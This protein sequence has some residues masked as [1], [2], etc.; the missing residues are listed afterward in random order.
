M[1]LLLL[2]WMIPGVTVLDSLPVAVTPALQES[3]RARKLPSFLRDTVWIYTV[4]Q[5]EDTLRVVV[6]DVLGKH[7]PITFAVAVKGDTVR[8]VQVLVYRE[9]YGGE[10]QDPRFLAH[11]QGKTGR[12]PLVPGKS[13]PRIAGATISVNA[14]TLGVRRALWLLSRIGGRP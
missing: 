14:I 13:V 10:I 4:L 11:F 2:A 1:T 12:D 3:V 5:E 6:D 7:E 9:P 8:F